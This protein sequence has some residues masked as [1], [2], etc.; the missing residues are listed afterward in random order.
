[1]AEIEARIEPNRRGQRLFRIQANRHDDS[2]VDQLFEVMFHEKGKRE[3]EVASAT[4]N[5]F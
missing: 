5:S 2:G 3:V 1:M 4:P